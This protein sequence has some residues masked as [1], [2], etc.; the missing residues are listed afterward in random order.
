VVTAALEA[1]RAKEDAA[2][3][4]PQRTKVEPVASSG[5]PLP[6]DADSAVPQRPVVP[7]DDARR[8]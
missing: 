6:S 7:A 1:Q 3:R 8:K 2:P 4:E 5:A